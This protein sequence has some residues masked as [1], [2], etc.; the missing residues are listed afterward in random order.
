MTDRELA[1]LILRLED[2]FEEIYYNCLNHRHP[3]KDGTVAILSFR[4]CWGLG[5]DT[6]YPD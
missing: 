4:R 3:I 2:E 1:V 5:R 6:G